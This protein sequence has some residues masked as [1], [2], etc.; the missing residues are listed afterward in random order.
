MPSTQD[1]FGELP[2]ELR[3]CIYQLL[4]SEND[5]RLD[6]YGARLYHWLLQVSPLMRNEVERIMLDQASSITT[7]VTDFDF[8]ALC[9]PLGSRNAKVTLDLRI[10]LRV[11]GGDSPNDDEDL[12]MMWQWVKLCAAHHVWRVHYIPEISPGVYPLQAELLCGN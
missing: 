12:C 7:T 11:T 4:I 1:L 10:V 9:A 6:L 8:R 2:P 5:V 3:L